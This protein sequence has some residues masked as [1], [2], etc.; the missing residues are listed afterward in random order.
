MIQGGTSKPIIAQRHTCVS[1]EN[2][3]KGKYCIARY[4]GYCPDRFFPGSYN[5]DRQNRNGKQD[6][7]AIAVTIAIR[8]LN[9][10]AGVM[11]TLTLKL[12]FHQPNVCSLALSGSLS[13]SQGNQY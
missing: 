11:A 5:E 12:F 9:I 7:I 2:P 4:G 6:P 1:G 8:K 13:E 10:A 3:F